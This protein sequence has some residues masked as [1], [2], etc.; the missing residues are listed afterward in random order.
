MVSGV[1][2][3]LTPSVTASDTAQ[4]TAAIHAVPS[5]AG[6]RSRARRGSTTAMAAAYA[7]AGHIDQV[8][9]RGTVWNGGSPSIGSPPRARSTCPHT[10][11]PA[12]RTRAPPRARRVRRRRG[13]V[14][15]GDADGARV[16]VGV[17]ASTLGTNPAPGP[18]SRRSVSTS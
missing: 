7:T 5:A 16:A 15:T 18:R 11:V 14:G 12:T 6:Q 8:S 17:M 3:R 1:H 10:S 2:S 9:S 13:A 4:P